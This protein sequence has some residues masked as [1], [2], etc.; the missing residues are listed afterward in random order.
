MGKI[1]ILAKEIVDRIAAGEVVTNPAAAIKELVENSI[2]ANA[3]NITIEIE[4]GGKTLIRVSDDGEGIANEDLERALMRNATSKVYNSLDGVSTL[5]FRG[6]ALASICIV[7]KMVVKSRSIADKTG[8]ELTAEYGIVTGQKPVPYA[9][10]TAIEARD[11]FSNVPARRKHLKKDSNETAA[12]ITVAG[13]LALSH[14][15]VAVKLVCDGRVAFHTD[16]SS[17]IKNVA[18]IVLGKRFLEGALD[19]DYNDEPLVIKGFLTSPSFIGKHSARVVILNGRYVRCPALNKAVDDAYHD[20]C[21]K[22]GAAFL[23][24]IELPYKYVDVNIHPAK[25]SVLL[26]NESLI[27]LMA[28][29]AIKKALADSFAIKEEFSIVGVYEAPWQVTNQMFESVAH[30]VAPNAAVQLPESVYSY[31][32]STFLSQ[33]MEKEAEIIVPKHSKKEPVQL[34]PKI[35]IDKSLIYAIANMKFVG[36]AFGVYSMFEVD[37]DIFIIDNHAAHERVLYEEYMAALK[38]DAIPI[39]NLLVPVAV[40]VDPSTEQAILNS[41]SLLAG[42]G[43]EFDLMGPGIAACRAIPAYNGFEDPKSLVESIV[44]ELGAGHIV[45]TYDRCESLIRRACHD[46]IRSSNE[47]SELEVKKLAVDLSN[48]QM[49]YVCPHGRP[50]ISRISKL[51]FM[52]AFERV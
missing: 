7:S 27:T 31:D 14:P 44:S 32:E 11:L 23:L 10:G 38:S 2:D 34:A 41:L 15:E 51:Q 46:A 47:I 8:L 36:C 9:I 16:G 24:Y 42:I 45:D 26:L 37:N 5:G 33:G 39:Q 18:A 35:E 20:V 25:T 3:S 40:D 1:Q 22:K 12:V 28:K 29:Q 43:F 17:D 48:T 50:I 21:G 4:S 19:L 30:Y 49:P 52:K 13:M 6:E